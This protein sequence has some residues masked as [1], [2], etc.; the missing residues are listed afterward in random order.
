MPTRAASALKPGVPRRSRPPVRGGV[1]RAGDHRIEQRAV[2]S[3]ERP[4]S[5]RR[6]IQVSDQQ[7]RLQDARRPLLM[8]GPVARRSARR[9]V[10]RTRCLPA[11]AGRSAIAARMSGCHG[12]AAQAPSARAGA[13]T[14]RA[15]STAAS[16][17]ARKI[18]QRMARPGF[19]PG[20]PR[21]SVVDRDR[22]NK[23]E[24][25]AILR[26]PLSAGDEQKCAICIRFSQ[27]RHPRC[28]P[29]CAR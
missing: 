22:S 11:G 21:F 9:F 1:V 26:V 25:P 5:H 16:D 19:E 28:R 7:H 6:A 8:V 2:G 23:V 17:A 4:V 18:A 20:T 29:S 24:S 3:S 10:P 14:V 15:A 13:A 12:R 27:V